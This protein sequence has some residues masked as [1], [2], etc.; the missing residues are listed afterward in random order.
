MDSNK[1][2]FNPRFTTCT[3]H[4][5]WEQDG[6]LQFLCNKLCNS[7]QRFF[8]PFCISISL[9]AFVAQGSFLCF[10]S[11]LRSRK[12][13]QTGSVQWHVWNVLSSKVQSENY[14]VSLIQCAGRIMYP[15]RFSTTNH[16]Q[17]SPHYLFIY[18]VKIY[19]LTA[20]ASASQ[21]TFLLVSQ[22]CRVTLK[23]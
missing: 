14:K 11:I 19:F 7:W 2:F 12:S 4:R 17:S 18:S 10:K 9:P 16:W 22:L 20:F 6:S 21:E 3:M 23:V 13:M 8:I 1:T 5:L 15:S